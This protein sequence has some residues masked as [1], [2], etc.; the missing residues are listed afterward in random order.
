MVHEIAVSDHSI[1]KWGNSM[2][3]IYHNVYYVYAY[4]RQKSSETALAGT[5]YYIGK[6][7]GRRAL[8][9]HHGIKVPEDK[10]RIVII[11][12]GLTEIGALALERRLI[13]WY[14]RKNNN[15]G[16]LLNRTDGG[17][18]VSGAIWT[19]TMRA[20]KSKRMSGSKWWNNGSTQIF[21]QIPPN[22]NFRPGRLLF[23]NGHNK[24][25]YY[26]NNG[27]ENKLSSNCPGPQWQRGMIR[28][29]YKQNLNTNPWWTDGSNKCRSIEQP[30]PGWWKGQPKNVLGKKWW[31]NGSKQVYQESSPGEN[32][33]LGRLIK[34]WTNGFENVFSNQSP[35]EGWYLG[36]SVRKHS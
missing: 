30:Y 12:H 29:T 26:W 14:G 6:G 25:K 19:N 28:K 10:H 18:G 31:N 32:W 17:D 35:G 34:W 15:T 2:S 33:Q 1:T 16:I 11:A 9:K 27:T 20:A 5:P 4:T 22:K 3:N 36:R 24:N 8:C 21:S 23:K 13:R 7:K